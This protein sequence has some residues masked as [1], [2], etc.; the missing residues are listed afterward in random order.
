M[1]LFSVL[2]I[3]AVFSASCFANSLE[4][5]FES[6]DMKQSCQRAAQFTNTGSVNFLEVINADDDSI[7]LALRDGNNGEFLIIDRATHSIESYKTEGKIQNIKIQD[8]EIL[9]T[10]DFELYVFNQSDHS[11]K[12]KTRSLPIHSNSVK[13]ARPYGVY[14]YKNI[15]YMAHGKFGIVPFDSV[16]MKHLPAIM[17]IVPQPASH[18]ESIVTDIAGVGEKAY[19][20]FDNYTLDQNFRG[21]EGLMVY[22]LETKAEEFT[23]PVK[24]TM[25]AYHMPNV[26][27]DGDELIVSNYNLNFRHTLKSLPRAKYMKPLRRIW[28]YPHG[29]LIGRGYIKDKKIY[30]CFK[31]YETKTITSGWMSLTK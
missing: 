8:K 15:Y 29:N 21:F 20:V 26:S 19:L 12:F 6:T 16:K 18:L 27:I 17:P 23:V 28:K 4:T 11:L 25:E 3:S 22:N 30:G 10:T 13:N 14:K 5:I 1:R 31:D 7:Y 2:F 24:Q 9:V